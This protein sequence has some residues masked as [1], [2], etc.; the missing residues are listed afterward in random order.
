MDNR[1]TRGI[2]IPDIT[3]NLKSP[4]QLN[5]EYRLLDAMDEELILDTAE[6]LSDVFVGVDIAGKKISE[7]IVDSLGLSKEDMFR[8]T[9]KYLRKL[10]CDGLSFVALDKKVNKVVAAVICE[11]FEP[12]KEVLVFKGSLA[13]INDIMNFF[14]EIDDRFV[15]TIE[16]NTGHK[17][18][19]DEYVKVFMAGSRLGKFRGY[20]I[21]KLI[22]LIMDKAR[23]NGYKGIFVKATDY[24]YAKVFIDYHSFHLVYN[25]ENQPILKE[26]SSVKAF[27]KIPY[28]IAKNCRVLYRTLVAHRTLL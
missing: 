12:E 4:S 13:P 21:A 15:R 23:K 19:K 6:C 24:R 16:F 7:P 28:N 1:F 18:E 27:N 2:A 26:Y 25:K 10:V 8:F 11:N 14:A 3:L 17:V 9:V 22:K 5:L 20:V